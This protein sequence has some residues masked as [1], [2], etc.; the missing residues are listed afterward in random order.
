MLTEYIQLDQGLVEGKPVIEPIDPSIITAEQ[1]QQA[2]NA[3]NLI[4]KKKATLQVKGRTCAEGSKQRQ[5][6]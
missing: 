6:F 1:K 4:K 5:H 3:V 2:M